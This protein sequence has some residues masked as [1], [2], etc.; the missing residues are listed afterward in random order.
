LVWNCLEK[1]SHKLKVKMF[2]IQMA[3]EKPFFLL[4]YRRGWAFCVAE[5]TMTVM[6]WCYIIF[7]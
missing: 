3:G 7:V 1:C 2:D 5:Y 4:V 6:S